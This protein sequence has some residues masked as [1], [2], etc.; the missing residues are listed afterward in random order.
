[1]IV[2]NQGKLKLHLQS[3]IA[4][5]AGWVAKYKTASIGGEGEGVAVNV[6]V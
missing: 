4:R 1:M 3:G 2:N 5:G 6:L